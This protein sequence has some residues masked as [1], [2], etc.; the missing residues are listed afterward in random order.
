MIQSTAR[1]EEL[2][3]EDWIELVKGLLEHEDT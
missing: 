2:A 1:A 3:N